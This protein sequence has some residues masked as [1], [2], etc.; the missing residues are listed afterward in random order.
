M[1]VTDNSSLVGQRQEAKGKERKE[2]EDDDG[3][4]CIVTIVQSVSPLVS[5][6]VT[7]VSQSAS[8]SLSQWVSHS[9]THSAKQSDETDIYETIIKTDRDVGTQ[10]IEFASS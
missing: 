8:Q 3:Y 9:H 2:E 5:G 6:P 10:C 7:P 4:P 1:F